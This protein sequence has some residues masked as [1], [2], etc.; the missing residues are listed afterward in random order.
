M[1]GYEKAGCIFDAVLGNAGADSAFGHRRHQLGADAVQPRHRLFLRA[2]HDPHQR[3]RTLRRQVHARPALYRRRAGGADRL[4]HE[5]HVHRDRRQD[6]QDRLAAQ[7]ALP[8]R[9]R[10]R[11]DRHGRRPGAS[12]ASRT[13]TSWRSMPRPARS[14]CAFQTGFGAD[15]PPVVYEV[16]GEQYI[17]I[18]TGGNRSRAAPMAMPSGCSR[19]RGSSA[20]CGHH[21]RRRR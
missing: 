19:S 3:I 2:R 15:A 21:R 13:A 17:A 20:R 7:D 16:D 1:P 5:R 11:L 8:P 18:A 10:G 4:D 6:Q 14:C 9:R 12:A